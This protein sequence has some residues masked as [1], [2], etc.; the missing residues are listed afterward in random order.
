MKAAR[1]A[2]RA[3]TRVS[4]LL[5]VVL[6]SIA[7]SPALAHE[8]H[9][10]ISDISFNPR[11]ANTEVVHTLVLHDVETAFWL[12]HGR[13][14]DAANPQDEALLKAALDKTFVLH[15]AAK[16]RLP[17]RWVGISAEADTLTIYQELPRTRIAPGTTLQHRVL[18]AHFPL[19]TH[20]VNV[21]LDGRT[22]TLK[23]DRKSEALPLK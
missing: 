23:F 1:A 21:R 8:F 19:Q 6:A 5:W 10:S 2:A 14:F 3:R 9:V 22:R 7:W 15:T 4:R 13:R 16:V 20:T 17:L 11:T 12:E 18:M